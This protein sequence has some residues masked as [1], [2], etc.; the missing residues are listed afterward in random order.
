MNVIYELANVE[1]R[2]LRLYFC[3]HVYIEY[4]SQLLVKRDRLIWTYQRKRQLRVVF[5]G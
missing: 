1:L 4:Q 3:V 5:E 2:F